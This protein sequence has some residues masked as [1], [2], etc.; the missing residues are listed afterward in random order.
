VIG[1]AIGW[2]A[3]STLAAPVADGAAGDTIVATVDREGEAVVVRVA[4]CEGLDA[5]ELARLLDLE[6]SGVTTEIRSG[7]PLLVALRCDAGTLSIEISDPLTRKQLTRQIPEPAPDPGRER[8]LALAVS[9]LFSASWLELLTPAPP[10]PTPEAV[11]PRQPVRDEAVAAATAVAQERTQPPRA[12][13]LLLGAGA[14]GRALSSAARVP[15]SHLDLLLR[16]WL[17]ASVGLAASFGWDFAQSERE[18][19]RIRGH[20]LTGAGGLAWR[21]RARPVIGLGGQVLAGV[22]WAQLSGEARA[23]LVP[24][25]ST[26]GLTAELSASVGPR[27]TSGRLRVDL[28]GE[29][30]WMLRTPVG[31]V[32]DEASF[33]LGGLWVGAVVRVGVDLRR[34]GPRPSRARRSPP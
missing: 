25:G 34:P 1:S 12:V 6:L 3:L 11:A 8:L 24:A 23:P 30:G 5:A 9:E 7:P 13:G 31:R 32:T 26:R 29:A 10:E 15:A 14:R 4:G 17:T 18:F 2:L 22:A 19:G 21:W 33:E 28:D 27:V 20:A 16:G